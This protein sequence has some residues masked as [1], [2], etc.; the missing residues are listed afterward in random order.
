MCS[1]SSGK[2]LANDSLSCTATPCTIANCSSCYTVNGAERC[3]R[4]KPN[5]AVNRTYG[6]DATT[7]SIN[8][9]RICNS[10]TGTC[11]TCETG[12]TA[13]PFQK[14]C[15]PVCT[16]FCID[17]IGPNFCYLCINGYRAVDGLCVID[18]ANSIVAN[19]ATCSTL[20]TCLSC[21]P[22]FNIV[23]AGVYCSSICSD[24]NCVVCSS[25]VAGTCTSCKIGFGLTNGACSSI[26]CNVDFC[27]TC[28]DIVTCSSCQPLFTLTNG[29]CSPDCAL[30]IPNCILCSTNSTCQVCRRG[31]YL[32]N[33]TC[34]VLCTIAN[35]D[36]CGS[37]SSCDACSPGYAL[38]FEPFFRAETCQ[39]TCQVE[40]C[41]NCSSP[42]T[43]FSCNPEYDLG[44][45]GTVCLSR[46]GFGQTSVAATPLVCQ[47]CGFSIIN[48]YTCEI[49]GGQA[50]CVDCRPGYFRDGYEHCSLCSAALSNCRNCSSPSACLNC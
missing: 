48:C 13:V 20:S 11:T 22:G 45:N 28:S 27:Q 40:N 46:C 24:A 25:S 37:S 38:S 34:Q 3:Y 50:Y 41:Q 26:I 1:L 42:T 36:Y 15:N 5:Y 4:C 16:E 33:N 21:N 7:C 12:Y 30:S 32:T 31:Y 47:N 14:S 18:C 43:C 9:C 6:C 39:L 35:C 49:L 17:C 44:S 19:C 10:T 23:L 2:S 29:T 8:G